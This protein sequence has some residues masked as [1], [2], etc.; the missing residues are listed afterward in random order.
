MEDQQRK[1][2]DLA[3]RILDENS[4]L[5]P[6]SDVIEALD[7]APYFTT[8]AQAWLER[9]CR[10]TPEADAALEEA[11]K[12]VARKAVVAMPTQ[13]ADT[14]YR[15]A[16]MTKGDIES[17]SFYPQAKKP[18]TP[19][20]ID[21][22]DQFL[23]T[24]TRSDSE[25]EALIEKLIF[26][27]VPDYASV[28][29]EQEKHNLPTADDAPE[30]SAEALIN[31]FIIK[32]HESDYRSVKTEIA[33]AASKPLVLPSPIADGRPVTPPPPPRDDS[34]LRESLAK[35]YIKRKRYRQA[36]E[37]IEQLNLNYPEKNI[38]FAP[39]LRFLAKLIANEEAQQ[40]REIRNQN[41]T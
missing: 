31:S 5:C 15:L 30:G 12:A 28:L 10:E 17:M 13:P 19:T 4:P 40:R 24:Y 37:I 38:Y 9:S 27:P 6:A 2:N 14:L 32:S 34:M 16:G 18:E 39:Q 20:T 35:F 23:T 11:R 22:I 8:L 41:K 1:Y 29:A 36:Y 25:E 3:S 26:N 33:E 7:A 21:T